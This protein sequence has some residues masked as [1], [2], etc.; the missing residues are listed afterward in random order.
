MKV[1]APLFSFDASGTLGGIITASK[2]RG[3]QYFRTRVIPSNPRSAGQTGIRAMWQFL[4]QQ[5][6]PSV[7]PGD[8]ATWEDP[9]ASDNVTSFNAYMRNNIRDWRSSLAPGM[10]FPV[11]RDLAPGTLG[12]VTTTVQG[13]NVNLD[14][15]VT[16]NGD[17]WGLAICRSTITGFTPDWSNTTKVLN[18]MTSP[19][20]LQYTDGPL[21]PGTYFY[22]GFLFSTNGEQSAAVTEDSAVV[23]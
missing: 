14:Y 4:S 5:W 19:T 6:A 20:Q 3:R 16:P 9:A 2:W 22:S 10:A 12:S 1:T 11:T 7:D 13:R 21:D 23:T 8:Q 15:A 17:E 18:A